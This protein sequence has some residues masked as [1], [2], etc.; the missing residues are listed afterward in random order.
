MEFE[1]E[2]RKAAEYIHHADA[3]LINTG[4]GMGVGSGIGTFRGKAAGESYDAFNDSYF[5]TVINDNDKGFG[6]L[7]S[8]GV[9]D[10]NK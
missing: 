2:L 4:A 1:E 3:L 10:L 9:F 5:V 8:K 6:N 7:W